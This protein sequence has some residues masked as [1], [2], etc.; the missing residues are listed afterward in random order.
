MIGWLNRRLKGLV[1]SDYVIKFCD[2]SF[3]TFAINTYGSELTSEFNQHYRDAFNVWKK[4][5]FFV[6]IQR[7]FSQTTR[8][9]QML[10][11]REFVLSLANDWVSAEEYISEKYTDEERRILTDKLYY[12]ETKAQTDAGAEF[13]YLVNAAM[14]AILR[15]IADTHFQD[16]TKTDYFVY[17]LHTAKRHI[18]ELYKV[19]IAKA[20]GDSDSVSIKLSEMLVESTG[21]LKKQ[22]WEAAVAGA[23]FDFDAEREEKLRLDEERKEE[24]NKPLKRERIY[25]DEIAQIVDI[26]G[27]R[28][29]RSQRNELYR[30]AGKESAEPIKAYAFDF[31]IVLIALRE[32]L[33]TEQLAEESLAEIILRFCK[34]VLGTQTISKDAV[35]IGFQKYIASES[36]GWKREVGWFFHL[37]VVLRQFLYED[38][39]CRSGATQ[40][41]KDEH[42]KGTLQLGKDSWALYSS[43]MNIFGWNLSTTCFDD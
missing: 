17:F 23:H 28:Y 31:A 13:C 30:I 10:G 35:N 16:A 6:N 2:S 19:T 18:A 24:A 14:A 41:E 40:R 33:Q 26:L 25:A 15:V 34:D 22:I 38:G 20:S 27:E 32:S 42:G 3:E 7:I 43:V 39:D 29:E 12:K 21:E 36:D 9:Q 1:S 5:Y 4:D 37:L 11:L 8:K